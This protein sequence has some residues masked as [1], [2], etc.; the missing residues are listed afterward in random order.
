MPAD[1]VIDNVLIVDVFG[2]TIIGPTSLAIA[3]GRIAG[4]GVG[5]VGKTHIDARGSYLSPGYI[6][7]H[8]HIESSLC[9]PG[10]FARAVVP[11]GVTCAV[12]DPH[13]IA[14]V[15]GDAGV[16]WM[17]A[18][19]KN[20][21]M[22]VLVNAPSCVPATHLA[23]AGATLTASDIQTLFDDAT[24]HGLAEMMNFP[25]AIHAHEG[26]MEKLAIARLD[27]RPIDGHAPG[28]TGKLLNAY[29]A[30][31]VGSDH[32]CIT[33][34]E[35]RDRIARGMIVFIRQATNAQNLRDLLPIITRENARRICFCTDD[36]TASDLLNEG[37]IDHMVRV[38]IE[39][40]IDP[41]EAIRLGTL[42]AAEWFGLSDLGA[43]APG[44]RANF[45]LFDDL[46]SPVARD[47]FFEGQRVASEGRAMFEV[48]ETLNAR[49]GNCVC[50]LSIDRLRI[51]ATASR[52]IVIGIR[53]DQLVTDRLLLDAKIQNG[54]A[55][56]DMSRDMLKMAVFERHGKSGSVGL[57]FVSGFGLRQ[58][59]VASTVAHDHHNLVVI[60]VDDESMIAAARR[61]VENGGGIAVANGKTILAE[62]ALPVGGLMSEHPVE[63][64]ATE[65][66]SCIDAARQLGSPLQD[67]LMQMSF[68]ALE[69]IP[70][71][72]LTDLGLVDVERFET[73]SI[74]T[75]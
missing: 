16:R 59:A 51:D 71:I 14:N 72:K 70:T 39:C 31:G 47:V 21:P 4:M 35:A 33:P 44:R 1:L 37:S 20:L 40:G 65:Y 8:V 56:S 64:V 29:V 66:Q 2:G 22:D 68:L 13:E 23:T 75:A 32:E 5:Y 48:A 58:G 10:E 36:R 57:G 30:S 73:V 11:R 49:L 50:E 41:I 45:F 46:R 27:S 19:S 63:R 67:P 43:I 24:C 60:G 54:Q 53:P 9:V 61:C 15:A 17:A 52:L 55:V 69:V 6:D 18:A 25:G 28:V 34:D 26:V 38:A 74:W 62:I 12:I 42:N 7:A 3:G